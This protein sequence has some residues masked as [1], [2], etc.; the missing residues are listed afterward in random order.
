MKVFPTITGRIESNDMCIQ[1]TWMRIELCA[2]ARFYFVRRARRG[3]T[4]IKFERDSNVS[5]ASCTLAWPVFSFVKEH[6]GF[7][8]NYTMFDMQNAWQSSSRISFDRCRTPE[9]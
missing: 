7:P 9:K 1:D 4:I 2:L 5:A 3:L 8:T 6:S